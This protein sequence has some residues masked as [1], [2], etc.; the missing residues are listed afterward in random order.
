[1]IFN[2]GFHSDYDWDRY[3]SQ[4]FEEENEE[5]EYLK[6]KY[7]G[8]TVKIIEMDG[9]PEYMGKEGVVEEVEDDVLFGTWGDM[10]IV[11]G[12]DSFEII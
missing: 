10:G 7:L 5:Q 3:H 4:F 8:K 6:E 2:E 11:V 1:M 9:E 12:R